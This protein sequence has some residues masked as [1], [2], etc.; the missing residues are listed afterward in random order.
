M[1]LFTWPLWLFASRFSVYLT[2]IGVFSSAAASLAARLKPA[3]E[4]R[5]WCADFCVTVSRFCN[6]AVY[7]CTHTHTHPTKCSAKTNCR[8]ASE[9]HSLTFCRKEKKKIF[10]LQLYQ[11]L[12]DREKG[13]TQLVNWWAVKNGTPWKVS[14]LTGRVPF[15]FKNWLKVKRKKR[16]KG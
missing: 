9:R 4:A 12:N 1:L 5:V 10:L 3:A 6:H 14:V 11:I 13:T 16:E 2:I 15:Y 8:T 7:T